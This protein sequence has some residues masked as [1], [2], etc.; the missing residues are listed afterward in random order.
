MGD[1]ICTLT[2]CVNSVYNMCTDQ[3]AMLHC[4]QNQM[5]QP[6]LEPA[7][8]V[9]KR[10]GKQA[11]GS[12]MH[13]NRKIGNMMDMN[14]MRNIVYEVV[15]EIINSEKSKVCMAEVNP[16]YPFSSICFFF[17]NSFHFFVFDF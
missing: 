16:M 6:P 17:K 1:S 8:S 3:E 11:T 12:N 5:P 9:G 2:G 4:H 14:K 15:H 7:Q 13:N 10:R